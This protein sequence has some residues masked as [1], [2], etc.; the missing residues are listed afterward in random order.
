M[1]MTIPQIPHWPSAGISLLSE[2]ERQPRVI[3]ITGERQSAAKVILALAA[4]ASD[5]PVSVAERVFTPSPVRSEEALLAR[6]ANARFVVDLECLCWRP[7]WRLD[8]VRLLRRIGGTRGVAAVWPGSIASREVA[9]ST[10]GRSDYVSATSA[11]LVVLRPL[12]TQFPDEVP[13]TI[14]RIPA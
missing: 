11:D 6:L 13:F 9:F 2:M 1:A 12:A 10:P 14:E 3:V 4:L 8:P 5:E 7:W